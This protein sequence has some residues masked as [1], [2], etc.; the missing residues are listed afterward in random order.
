[1]MSRAE[2]GPRML[3]LPKVDRTPFSA[4]TRGAEQALSTRSVLGLDVNGRTRVSA[5]E[6]EIWV[7]GPGIG[8]EVLA[9]GQSLIVC[10]S[11]RLVVQALTAARVR[12]QRAE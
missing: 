12:I 9:R 5:L 2:P 1:M 4:V 3:T 11:G 8:D 10:G 7:T 6:G